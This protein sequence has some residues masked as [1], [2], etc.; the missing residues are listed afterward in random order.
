MFGSI[1]FKE[2]I[3]RL[4]TASKTI[5]VQALDAAFDLVDEAIRSRKQIF[6]CGNGGSGANAIHMEND[7]LYGVAKK[8]GYGAKISALTANNAVILCLANDIGYEKIF[9]EQLKVKSSPGDLLIV[10]SGS[11]N[12]EN[13]IEALQVAK[14]L[15]LNS[16]AIVGFTGGAAKAMADISLHAVVD[17]MQI[18]EDIQTAILHSFMQKIFA[19]FSKKGHW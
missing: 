12:S 11:G 15:S 17:D 2:Y 3:S 7:F 10:L 16:I 18:S 19:D 13:I 5:N 9:S 6:I 8:S 14:E 4:E 1:S